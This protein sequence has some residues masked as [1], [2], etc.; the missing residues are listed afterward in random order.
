MLTFPV[1]TFNICT[2]TIM[3]IVIKLS[4]IQVNFDALVYVNSFKKPV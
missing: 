4:G 3:V 1:S 2:E